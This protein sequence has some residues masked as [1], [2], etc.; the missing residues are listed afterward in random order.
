MSVVTTED[1]ERVFPEPVSAGDIADGQYRI[2]NLKAQNFLKLKAIDITPGDANVI[3]ISGKNGAGKSSVLKAIWSVFA[4]REISKT[5]SSPIRAGEESGSVSVDLGDMTITRSWTG[6]DTYLRIENKKGAVYRSPQALLDK[7]KTS[8][9]FDPLAFTR[10]APKEQRATLLKVLGVDLDSIEQERDGYFNA[11]TETNRIV[12]TLTAQLEQY[13]ALPADLPGEPISAAN[14]ITKIR[15]AEEN[16]R[17]ITRLDDEISTAEN[18]VVVLEAELKR[19]KDQL[20]SCISARDTKSPVDV[21]TFESQLSNVE[22]LNTLIQKR[23][24]RDKIVS[25]LNEASK[26]SDGLTTKI[27]E[28]DKSKKEALKSAELP[29]P[30]IS[31]TTEGITYQDIPLSQCSAAEQIRVSVAMGAALNPGL[32]VLLIQDGSL[33]D[34]TSRQIIEDLAEEQNMQV[35][36]ETVSESGESGIVIEDGEIVA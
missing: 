2:I 30:D 16:N 33:C 22:E 4:N 25:E 1:I 35:W 23:N 32:R 19:V 34:S 6:S 26:K 12:K 20:E 24:T 7:L 18:K 17:E 3:E 31:I 14:L 9:S 21:S 15:E 29:I 28:L 8:L 13:Q 11:R 27:D 5:I 10:M 36:I